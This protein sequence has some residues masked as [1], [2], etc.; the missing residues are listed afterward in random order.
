MGENWEYDD[1]N[2]EMFH[3][4]KQAYYRLLRHSV[5]KILAEIGVSKKLLSLNKLGYNKNI[6]AELGCDEKRP[7]NMWWKED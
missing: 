5:L 7:Y 4:L 2:W 3:D 6:Y 1:D